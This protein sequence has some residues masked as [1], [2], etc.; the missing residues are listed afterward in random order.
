MDFRS[1]ASKVLT[2]LHGKDAATCFISRLNDAEI[3]KL[4]GLP[5]PCVRKAKM[6]KSSKRSV[7]IKKK[8]KHI[9]VDFVGFDTRKEHDVDYLRVD[10]KGLKHSIKYMDDKDKQ[11][12]KDK[13]IRVNYDFEFENGP[14]IE[15]LTSEKGF[16]RATLA[17]VIGLKYQELFKRKSASKWVKDLATVGVKSVSLNKDGVYEIDV[18]IN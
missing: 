16:T 4:T 2:M 9:F 7:P 14:F 11:V 6:G 3:S 13:R 15:T 8:E 18:D 1:T 5:I 17:R 12:I 10:R